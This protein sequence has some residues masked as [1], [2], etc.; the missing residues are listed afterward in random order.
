MPTIE[1]KERE[2]I[3]KSLIL[4]VEGTITSTQWVLTHTWQFFPDKLSPTSPKNYFKCWWLVSLPWK[5][6]PVF[7]PLKCV[8]SVLFIYYFHVLMI[9]YKDIFSR[10][11]DC[12]RFKWLATFLCWRHLIYHPGFLKCQSRASS[13]FHCKSLHSWKGLGWTL[14]CQT[15]CLMLPAQRPTVCKL[16]TFWLWVPGHG[17]SATSD[18]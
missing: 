10:I 7:V 11:S 6:I 16:W 14:W 4:N 5:T 2:G 1:S 8:F 13:C 15:L 17:A 9:F 18:D 12:Q 3:V